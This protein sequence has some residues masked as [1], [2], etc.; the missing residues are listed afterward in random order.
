M[1]LN[2]L[3]GRKGTFSCESSEDTLVRTVVWAHIVPDRVMSYDLLLGRDRWDLFPLRKYRDTNEDEMF[4]IVTAQ[5]E[6]SAAGDHRFKKWVDQAIGMIK[7]PTGCKVDV[8]HADKS[9]MLSE[10]F[11]LV[12]GELRN[13][14][15]S[16]ADPGS[17]YVRF[18]DGWTPKKAIVDAG[19]SEIPL[20]WTEGSEHH[21]YSQTTLG[22]ASIRL[23]QVNLMNA[24]VIPQD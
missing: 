6:G 23:R 8:R 5:D 10:G 9:C 19:L 13:C 16:A 20:Q 15:G 12:K 17:Y 21:F 7:S 14:G 1:R 3:L 11:T 22:Y 4:V 2:V 18:Q 24:E